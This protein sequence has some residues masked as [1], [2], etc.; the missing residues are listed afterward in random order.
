MLHVE[1]KNHLQ[2][3]HIQYDEIMSL[4]ERKTKFNAINSL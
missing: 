3:Y 2:E 4:N 1:G